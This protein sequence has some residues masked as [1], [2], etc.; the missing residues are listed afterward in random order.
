MFRL[1]ILCLPGSANYQDSKM[2]DR[3]MMRLGSFH[4]QKII[5]LSRQIRSSRQ[6]MYEDYYLENVEIEDDFNN[7]IS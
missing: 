7:L 5:S 1:K 2:K 6:S 4:F 3:V